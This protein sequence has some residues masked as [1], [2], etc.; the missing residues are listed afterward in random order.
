MHLG[1]SFTATFAVALLLIFVA[2]A[3]EPPHLVAPTGPLEPAAER[4]A[5]RLPEGFEAQLVVSEPAINKPMNIAFD[6]RGRLWVTSTV[7]Y[8]FPAPD[9]VKPRD[10]FQIDVNSAT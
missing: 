7:E 10:R 1:R 2:N 6:D 9:S 5:F 3:E 8:P 4:A